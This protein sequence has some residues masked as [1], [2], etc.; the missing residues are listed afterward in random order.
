MKYADIMNETNLMTL[1]ADAFTANREYGEVIN[2]ETERGEVE[3][4]QKVVADKV[5]KY[6]DECK[7]FVFKAWLNDSNPMKAAL[8][9][10]MFPVLKASV[11][12]KKGSQTTAIEDDSRI[13][14]VTDF[15]DY[16]V[17]IG[18]DNPATNPAWLKQAEEAHKAL[19]GFLVV[20]MHSEGLKA[21]FLNEFDIAFNMKAGDT[22]CG[23]ADLKKR[24]SLGNID[25]TLQALLDA[26]LYEDVTNGGKNKYRVQTN[27][28]NIIRY[29]YAKLSA[30]TIGEVLF[31]STKNFMTD[32][33]KVFAQIVR[34][35]ETSF[36]GYPVTTTEK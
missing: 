21:Q 35:N 20:E 28:R 10:G 22:L 19:C 30:K 5:A 7:K 32:I 36:N 18:H 26:I 2:N 14:T 6:N 12:G 27:H 9:D 23:E 31:K 25:R 24:F 3:R 13:F 17:E 11:K 15:I 8:T 29:T 4:R 16:A 1:R 33:T 34:G